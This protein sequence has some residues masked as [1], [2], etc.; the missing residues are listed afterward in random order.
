[1]SKAD[2]GTIIQRLKDELASCP[3]E[4]DR[5]SLRKK[6][7]QLQLRLQKMKEVREREMEREQ[8]VRNVCYSTSLILTLPG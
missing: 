1:M 4:G 5:G 2:L 3:K 7:V 6:I 8:R